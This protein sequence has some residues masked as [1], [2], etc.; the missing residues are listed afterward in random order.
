MGNR[1]NLK[2]N[3]EYWFKNSSAGEKS[4]S[5]D[6]EQ[7]KSFGTYE[8]PQ[9]REQLIKAHIAMLSETARHVSDNLSFGA[10]VSDIAGVLDANADDGEGA[11]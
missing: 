9:D 10:D 2:A 8:V 7:P 5:T 4:M 3:R 11:Q 1:G 6:K